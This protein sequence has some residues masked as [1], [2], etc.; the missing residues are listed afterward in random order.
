M[1]KGVVF[2]L[3]NTVYDYD[4]CHEKAMKKL[5]AFACKKYGL[6]TTEFERNFNQA[7]ADVKE[8]LGN[9]GAS[10]NRMLYMQVFLESIGLRPT[11]DA[12]DLYNIYWDEL[13]ANIKL[14]PYVLPLMR[15][16][17]ERGIKILVLTDLT[18]HI[19]HRKIAKM[20][21]AG[22]I[23]IFVSSEEAGEEKPSKK[24]FD[25]LLLK[26]KL[27]AEELL[28]IGDSQEKDIDGSKSAGLKALLYKKGNGDCMDEI[29][30]EYIDEINQLDSGKV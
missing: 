25:R 14:F 1:I 24:A 22:Y 17:K 2:D 7:K 30:M 12:L 5:T 3:D 23:D 9:T 18:A 8:Q 26:A 6:T 21:L 29:C 28:M 10:H 4:F 16:L 11:E 13:L 20:G 19:Q 27:N 15:K